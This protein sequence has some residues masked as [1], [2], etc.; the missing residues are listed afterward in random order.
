MAMV[1]EQVEIGTNHCLQWVE[2]VSPTLL[3][4]LTL[5]EGNTIGFACLLVFATVFV[6]KMCI[7]ALK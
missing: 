6:I 2:M 1:C 3:P 5:L 7:K 4:K